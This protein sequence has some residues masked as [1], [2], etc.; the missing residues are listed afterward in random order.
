[1]EGANDLPVAYLEGVYVKP[2]HQRQGIARKLIRVAEGW[3]KQKGV[4]QIASDAAVTN[5][6]SIHFHKQI[7]FEEAAR[8]VCFIKNL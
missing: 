4:K 5:L 1:M 3:A 2:N 6:T 7:G 8:I